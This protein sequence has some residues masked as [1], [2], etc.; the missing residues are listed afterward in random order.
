[1]GIVA[2]GAFFGLSFFGFHLLAIA[3][4]AYAFYGMV[5]KDKELEKTEQQTFLLS[6][7]GLAAFEV[8]AVVFTLGDFDNI[9]YALLIGGFAYLYSNRKSDMVKN[10]RKKFRTVSASTEKMKEDIKEEVKNVIK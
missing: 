3:A 1:M 4:L 7:W 10:L 8:A 2:L 9:F 6:I 5:L